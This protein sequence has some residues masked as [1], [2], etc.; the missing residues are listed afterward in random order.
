M[1]TMYSINNYQYIKYLQSG[2]MKKTF[3]KSDIYNDKYTQLKNQI[4]KRF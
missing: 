1:R 2:R 3:N 4:K